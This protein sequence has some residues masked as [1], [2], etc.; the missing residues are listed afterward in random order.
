MRAL[1]LIALLAT[2]APAA[3]QIVQIRTA[4]APLGVVGDGTYS[5]FGMVGDVIAGRSAGGAA[6]VWHGFLGGAP[7]APTDVPKPAVLPAS[8]FA[9]PA[10]M[11]AVESTRLRFGLVRAES[12][13]RLRI[14]DVTGRTVATLVNGGLAGGEHRLAWDLRDT[15]GARVRAGVYFARLDAASLHQTHRIIVER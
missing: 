15:R 6:V 10:P 4:L 8:F 3:A 7:G 1:I 13:V 9:C 12:N 14:F 5:H 2:A 11:P